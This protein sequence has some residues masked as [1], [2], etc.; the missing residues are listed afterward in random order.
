MGST[1]RGISASRGASVLGPKGRYAK[2]RASHLEQDRARS[3]AYY[4]ANREKRHQDWKKYYETN[5]DR[6]RENAKARRVEK[7]EA[8]TAYNR[9]YYHRNEETQR[10]RTAKYR[11]QNP[12][13]VRNFNRRYYV[14]RRHTDPS[15]KVVTNLRNRI[16]G[17]LRKAHAGKSSGTITLIGCTPNELKS[18][19]ESQ[20]LPGMSWD[21]H[22]VWHI[23][24]IRPCASFDLTDS[25]Q[26]RACFHFTNLQPLWA[27]DNIRKGAHLGFA[28]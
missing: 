14:E 4:R 8:I 21:N 5:A 26:Q 9:E 25:T 3:R 12:E 19:L 13:N 22:G 24:H 7:H 28:S 20:F 2:W 27:A 10:Q 11:K 16:N 6:L 15:F 23:D 17:L 18:H 1:P